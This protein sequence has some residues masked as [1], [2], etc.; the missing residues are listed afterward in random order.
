MNLVSKNLFHQE[1][2]L[3]FHCKPE[4]L[5]SYLNIGYNILE[6]FTVKP[7]EK[8]NESGDFKFDLNKNWDV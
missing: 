5:L 4:I 1:N 6:E 2:L 8:I 7:S 3:N